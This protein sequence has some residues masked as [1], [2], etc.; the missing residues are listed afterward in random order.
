M[1]VKAD[2]SILILLPEKKRKKLEEF[3]KKHI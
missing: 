1:S 3:R 2:R